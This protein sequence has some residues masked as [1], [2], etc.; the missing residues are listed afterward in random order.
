MIVL[1]EDYGSQHWTRLEWRQARHQAERDGRQ[2]GYLLTERRLNTTSC[3]VEADPAAARRP[4]SP[5]DRGHGAEKI[6]QVP[7]LY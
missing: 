4:P 6:C 7:Q 3:V 1:S 5:P 2:V